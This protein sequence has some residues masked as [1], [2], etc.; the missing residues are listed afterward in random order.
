[1]WDNFASQ[2]ARTNFDPVEARILRRV[3]VAGPR[4]AAV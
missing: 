2:H 3:A 1:M 4:P